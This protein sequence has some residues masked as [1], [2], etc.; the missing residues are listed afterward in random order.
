MGWE[1]E[2][3]KV[4]D[5]YDWFWG[6]GC[7]GVLDFLGVGGKRENEGDCCLGFGDVV[8]CGGGLSGSFCFFWVVLFLSILSFL[9]VVWWWVRSDEVLWFGWRMLLNMMLYCFILILGILILRSWVL[10]L[11]L[12]FLVGGMGFWFLI[13]GW[14]GSGFCVICVVW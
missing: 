10:G 11:F 4:G 1:G 8:F 12:G 3:R 2:G 5:V 14:L 6:D 9:S 7:W 13:I